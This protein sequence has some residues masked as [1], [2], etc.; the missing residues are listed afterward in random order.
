MS[1]DR[2]LESIKPLTDRLKA[3][4]GASAGDGENITVELGV[5]GLEYTLILH[6]ERVEVIRGD[7]RSYFLLSEVPRLNHV[8]MPL[9]E[10][11]ETTGFNLD[12]YELKADDI[13][14]RLHLIMPGD[15]CLSQE[16]VFYEGA[17]TQLSANF[18]KAR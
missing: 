9:V 16:I 12:I 7:L 10:R 3:E 13:S 1:I 6:G 17:C 15:F 2:F 5:Y 8:C 14:L 11:I 18:I 4:V